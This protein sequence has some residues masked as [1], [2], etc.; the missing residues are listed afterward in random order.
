MTHRRD[1]GPNGQRRVHPDSPDYPGVLRRCSNSGRPIPVTAYGSFGVLAHPAVG[2]FCSVRTPGDALLKTYD[3]ARALR[4]TCVT[5]VGGFQSPMEKEFLHLLLRGSA[6]AVV[7]PARGLGAM[8]L[9]R[10]WNI[11][12]AG[13]RWRCDKESRPVPPRTMVAT[14]L[15][16]SRGELQEH[17]S[18]WE[19]QLCGWARRVRGAVSRFRLRARRPAPRRACR[20]ACWPCSSCP[21]GRRTRRPRPH[22]GPSG[23]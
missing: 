9:P 13:G 15:S 8:R 6:A 12:V 5:V 2:F 3:L 11:A 22:S 19:G 7:C 21:R 14:R 23:P 18:F 4:D 20:G 17:F 10:D 1:V 16:L